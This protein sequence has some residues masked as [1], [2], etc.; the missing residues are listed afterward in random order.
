M[1]GWLL[2]LMRQTSGTFHC[3]F[4]HGISVEINLYGIKSK[5]KLVKIEMV[6]CFENCFEYIL[7]GQ[8]IFWN[9]ISI[10]LHSGL[11]PAWHLWLST[12]FSCCLKMK[13]VENILGYIFENNFTDFREAV[14]LENFF[15]I[16]QE[17]TLKCSKL[18]VCL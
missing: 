17:N 10:L 8:N 12:R 14:S 7:L 15:E 13:S 4:V 2:K 1:L 5:I 11:N 6:F 9:R 16:V 3:L 18:L